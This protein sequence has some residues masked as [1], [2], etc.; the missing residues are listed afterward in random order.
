MAEEGQKKLDEY[1]R[2]TREVEHPKEH[3]TE[4]LVAKLNEIKKQ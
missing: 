3:G 2:L 1:V 4:D